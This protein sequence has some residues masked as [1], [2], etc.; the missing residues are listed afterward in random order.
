MG[1]LFHNNDDSGAL[2]F[3]RGFLLVIFLMGVLGSGYS[4][5]TH[6]GYPINLKRD[7]VDNPCSARHLNNM[8]V[9]GLRWDD[10]R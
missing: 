9:T 2:G 8:E 7:Y 3:I 6:C 1:K 5:L 4:G 10:K